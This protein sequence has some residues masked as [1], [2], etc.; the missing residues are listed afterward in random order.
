MF[1]LMDSARAFKYLEQICLIGARYSGSPGMEKQQKLITGHFMKF[2]CQ[3]KLQAFDAPHP[4][5]GQPVRMNNIIISWHPESKDR[6]LLCAH[7]DTRPFPDREISP[8]ARR[9]LFVGANDG[10]SGVALFMEMAHHMDKIQPGMGVD[11]VLFD[12]EELVFDRVGR[13]FLGADFFAR[14]YRDAPPAYRYRYGILVDMIAD[15]ELTLYHE[16]NS[17]DYAPELVQ[18]VWATAQRLKVTEFKHR[19]KHEVQDDHLP[20]NDVARIPTIDLIDFDY[21]HWHTRKD[22]PANCSG[23]SIA[24][25]GYVL[26]EWLKNVPAQ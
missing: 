20:L 11:F 3:V 13:Y 9:G 15:K 22:T 24:K 10:A 1:G 14:Q 19:V 7:Y 16:Q 17:V 26:M 23:E 6:V 4:Q 12:G 2:G 21:D 5:T 18:S 25:V 8:A